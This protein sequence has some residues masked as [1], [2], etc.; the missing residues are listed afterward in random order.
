MRLYEEN[1]QKLFFGFLPSFDQVSDFTGRS[2]MVTKSLF[3]KSRYD[4]K[5][6]LLKY[7]DKFGYLVKKLNRIQ[8]FKYEFQP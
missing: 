8:V 3:E 1:Y 6:F 7:N 4:K 2:Q 5:A